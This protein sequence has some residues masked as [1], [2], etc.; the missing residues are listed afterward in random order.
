MA[1]QQL[2][3][4]VQPMKYMLVTLQDLEHH[5]RTSYGASVSYMHNNPPIPFQGICQGNGSGPTI[6]FAVG[7]PLI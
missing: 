5:I 7:A 3:I 4:P 6:W 2:V 1:M